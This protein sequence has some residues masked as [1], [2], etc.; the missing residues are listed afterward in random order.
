MNAIFGHTLRQPP[1]NPQAEQALLGGLLASNKA[2]D[3]VGGLLRE[4]HFADP[5]HGRIYAAIARRIDG[6]RLADAVTLAR[7]SADWAEGFANPG[8]AA[9]YLGQL[10]GAMVSPTMIKG[11]AEAVLD[12]WHRRALIEI[13]EAMVHRGYSPGELSAR[14]IHE[15]AE[16]ALSRLAEGQDTE[17]PLVPGHEA[18]ALAIDAA[19]AARDRPGLLVGLTTGLR[20]LDRLTGGWRRGQLI[21]VGARPSMG[22]TSFGLS[23]AGAAAA[24]GA[25][26]L[27]FSMEM[28]PAQIGAAL[29]AG[30]TPIAR[31]GAIRGRIQER[32]EVGRFTYRP[33]TD[34]EVEAMT[35]AQRAM[36]QRNL[37]VVDLHTKTL[38]AVRSIARREKRRGGVDLVVIDYL[39]L[40]HVPEL[41]SSDNRV[42]EITRLSAG[43]KALARDL[44]V[45]VVLLSQLNRAVEQR[46]NKRPMLSDLRDSGSIEQDAD[47][48]I[49]LYRHH[50]YLSRPQAA[51]VRGERDSD[52]AYFN[53]VSAHADALEAS[54]GR[55][56][57]IVEKWR[58]GRIG[59]AQVAFGHET[60]WFTDLEDG[61]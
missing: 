5:V 59:T 3:S 7:E 9:G 11:Y 55:A 61:R 10:L 54:E 27:F 18:M 53:R 46:E 4:E 41:G 44:D 12:C 20:E 13:G 60:T 37:V 48:V 43:S 36:A 33:I 47:G 25:R 19:V 56:E 30:T 16:E 58:E 35:L 49:F 31:D 15:Q 2:Y 17:N 29:V 40:M 1:S 21:V 8:E 28:S 45:P 14:A 50:Y 26:V 51:P 24:Q 32:D 38:N 22:K 57:V 34:R 42:L 39:G 52:E 23:V 6:G